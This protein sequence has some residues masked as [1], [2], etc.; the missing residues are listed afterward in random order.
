MREARIVG[1][2]V[3]AAA[4]SGCGEGELVAPA[5]P[6]L[7]VQV[8]APA[9]IPEKAVI[10][11]EAHLVRARG[12]TPP[13]VVSFEKANAGESFVDVGFI[14]LHDLDRPVATARIPVF[15]D[16]TIRATARDASGLEAVSVVTIDVL[17][18]P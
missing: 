4:V 5:G 6:D 10:G 17:E 13:V 8:V 3:V 7:A 1:A 11:I 2:M 9:A 12:V 14:V 18:Y 15:K 16:P